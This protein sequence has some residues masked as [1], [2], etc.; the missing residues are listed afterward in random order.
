MTIDKQRVAKQFSRSAARYDQL[1]EIQHQI[2]KV[3]L[4]KL[5]PAID[6][7]E[8]CKLVDLGCGTGLLLAELAERSIERFGLDIADGMIREARLRLQH[9]SPN[10]T[11]VCG[12]LESTPFADDSF[13][14]VISNAAL[15]WCHLPS[16]L[17]EIKRILRKCETSQI[18][19]ST[20]GPGTLME[21]GQAFRQAGIVDPPV[22][23]FPDA[24]A[25]TDALETTGFSDLKIEQQTIRW[26]FGDIDE[27]LKSVRGIGAGYAGP[28]R[29]PI[30]R[31]HYFEL[32]NSFAAQ[33]DTD[34]NVSLT[35][36][37]I[38]VSG[39]LTS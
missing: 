38:F 23:E 18:L 24:Q 6:G 2:G 1:A 36:Q 7:M 37:V 15:Q 11:L 9:A 29:K 16:A 25:V 12:D 8:D 39:R 4:S 32:R 14:V 5:D 22:H 34:G 35:Y 30:S 20:F 17:S 31:K 13:D 28:S 33:T 27:M 19:F 3:L 26:S 21:W 10:V